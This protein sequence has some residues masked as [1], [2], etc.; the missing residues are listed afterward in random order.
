MMDDIFPKS[1]LRTY[2]KRRRGAVK[3]ET[4]YMQHKSDLS[5]KGTYMSKS[6]KAVLD[7]MV[8]T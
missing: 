3:K 7:K 4:L 6:Y 8:I 5:I 1:K 2:S